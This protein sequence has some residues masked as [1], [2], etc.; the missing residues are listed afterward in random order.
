MRTYRAKVRQGGRITTP[1]EV[2]KHLRLRPGN[3]VEYLVDGD[4]VILQRAE[5]TL[6]DV[7]GSVKPLIPTT[8]MDIEDV[9]RLAKEDYFMEKYGSKDE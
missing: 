9:I 3:K 5:L 7:F 6:E 2:R 4:R 8:G 1:V